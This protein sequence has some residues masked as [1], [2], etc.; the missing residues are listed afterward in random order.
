MCEVI[1]YKKL[2]GDDY[3]GKLESVG[4]QIHIQNKTK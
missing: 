3:C 1:K 2:W 4:T